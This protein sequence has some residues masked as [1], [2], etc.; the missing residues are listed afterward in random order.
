MLPFLSLARSLSSLFSLPS[1]PPLPG[2]FSPF[3][4]LRRRRRRWLLKSFARLKNI[5]CAL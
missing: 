2:T 5:I 1:P 3:L 4:P